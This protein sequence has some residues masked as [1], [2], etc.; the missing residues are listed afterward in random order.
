MHGSRLVL[1]FTKK[2]LFDTSGYASFSVIETQTPGVPLSFTFTYFD[3]R[4]IV[5]AR[6]FN[7]IVPNTPSASINSISTVIPY[8]FG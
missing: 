7:T 4:S 8:D 6:L 5:N 1:P 2:A 3:G